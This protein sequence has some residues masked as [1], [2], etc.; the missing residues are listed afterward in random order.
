M[1]D[2]RR[3]FIADDHPFTLAGV[4]AEIER[5]GEARVAGEACNGAALLQLL[6][7]ARPGD[8]LVTDFSMRGPQFRDCDGLPLLLTL[9]RQLP[10]LPIIVL[11]DLDNPAMLRAIVDAGVRGLVD[12]A[13]APGEL[14]TAIR[15]VAAGR[16]HFC[17]AMRTMLDQAGGPDGPRLR[18]SPH[19]AEVV[20][21]FAGGLTVS[22]IAA[23]LSRS[24]KTI[25]RQKNDAMH[26]LG[27]E[28]NCQLY[29]YARDHGLSP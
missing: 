8:L 14:L 5:A 27:L 13:S 10:A 1:E 28:N 20:R 7:D 23:R 17:R 4:R 6:E 15:K 26:K 12:K 21:L 29:A 2:R 18:M 3:V 16:I 19:E 25:S 24:V 11:T 22:E 9:R